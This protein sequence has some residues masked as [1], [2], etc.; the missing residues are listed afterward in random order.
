MVLQRDAAI[1]V[2][3]PGKTER[4]ITV[5]FNKQ[6]QTTLAGQKR[7]NGRSGP[8]RRKKSGADLSK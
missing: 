1:P 2:L 3:G 4:E 5:R 8:C 6:T 7:Q